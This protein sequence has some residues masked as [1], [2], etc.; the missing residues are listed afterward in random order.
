[1]LPIST[2]MDWQRD[3]PVVAAACVVTAAL[4][5]AARWRCRGLAP[6]LP[7]TAKSSRGAVD[8]N[9]VATPSPPA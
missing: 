9:D 3:W 5:L 1:M 7:V 2:M 4:T 8:R 6:P